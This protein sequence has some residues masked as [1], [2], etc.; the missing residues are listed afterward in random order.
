MINTVSED[1]REGVS[2]DRYSPVSDQVLDNIVAEIKQS[3]PNDGEVLLTGHLRRQSIFLPRTRIRASI[4]R[5]DPVGTAARRSIAVRR[6]VYHADGPNYVWHL[7]GHHKLI[8]YR[9][10]TH[11]AIDGY[12]RLITFLKCSNNNR[13]VTVLSCFSGAVQEHGLP[14]HIR[15]DLGRENIDVWRCMMEQQSNTSCVITGS[16]THNERVERLWRDVYRCV[17]VLFHDTFKLLEAD[18]KLDPL[19]EV[20]VYCLHYVYIPRIQ[21]TLDSFVESWNNHAISTE[22]NFTPNQ[23][24][25]RGALEYDMLPYYPSTS[26]LA[27]HSNPFLHPSRDRVPVPRINFSPCLHLTASIGHIDPLQSTHDFGECLYL[28]TVSL[29]GTHLTTC[30]VC[31]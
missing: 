15:S 30:N 12:S 14:T 2:F 7:D 29:V 11:A 20:D 23:L 26:Q 6:R 28:E 5:I 16:S 8:K 22:N 25:I 18:G 19:N 10:V 3:H 4:H 13:A 24:Y 1:G 21:Q 9:L 17:V 31:T 27:N